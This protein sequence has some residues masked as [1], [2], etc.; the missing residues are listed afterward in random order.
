MTDSDEVGYGKPPR[1][2]RFK[3]GQSGNPKGRPRG[4]KNLKTD[5]AEELSERISVREGPIQRKISKQ[6]AVVKSLLNNA[7]KGDGR[8]QVT[9]F[10]IMARLMGPENEKMEAATLNEDEAAIL[11]HFEE[12]LLRRAQAKAQ[13]A[14]GRAPAEGEVTQ[15]TS[16]EIANKS[17]TERPDVD[18]S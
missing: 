3:K 9:L 18:Q 1:E 15:A 5:L 12:R 8:A 7:I 17:A 2:H 4:T 10:N 13:T 11:A 14:S 6:R 16:E